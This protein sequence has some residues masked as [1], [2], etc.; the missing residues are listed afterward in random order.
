MIAE[1]HADGDA[2]VTPSCLSRNKCGG[3]TES[4]SGAQ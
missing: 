4:Q 2:H 1:Y 3:S